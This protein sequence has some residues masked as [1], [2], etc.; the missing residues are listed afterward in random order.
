MYLLTGTT[1][2]V[3]IKKEKKEIEKYVSCQHEKNFVFVIHYR[4]FSTCPNSKLSVS[5]ERA[6]IKFILNW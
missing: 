1:S 5:I 3:T 6:L 4:R 2:Y